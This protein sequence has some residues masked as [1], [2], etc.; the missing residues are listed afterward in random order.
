MSFDTNVSK[1][2]VTVRPYVVG[3]RIFVT[4]SFLRSFGRSAYAEGVDA[5]DLIDLLEPLLIAWDVKVAESGGELLGWVCTKAPDVVAWL[6]VKPFVRRRGLA[7]VLLDAAGLARTASGALRTVLAPFVPTKLFE[8]PF[9]GVAK[10]H[11]Y[12]VRFRPFL[13]RA[14][15][16]G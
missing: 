11:G 6:Y 2:E 7:R 4:D 1:A 8:E 16:L 9:Q 14:A 13:A 3:D 10:R 15:A 12:N 5:R